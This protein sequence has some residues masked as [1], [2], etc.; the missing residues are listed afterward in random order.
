M[1]IF[2]GESLSITLN[3]NLQKKMATMFNRH[4]C[5]VFRNKQVDVLLSQKNDEVLSS[6][7]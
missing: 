1:A 3:S 6:P 4:T 5:S 7:L 2:M